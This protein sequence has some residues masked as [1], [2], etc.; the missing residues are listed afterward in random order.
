MNTGMT[1]MSDLVGA[2]KREA[3]V[4][5]AFSDAYPTVTDTEIRGALCDAFAAA[6]LDGF[7]G[8]LELDVDGQETTPD[9]S[10][11]GAALVVIYAGERLVRQQI[12]GLASQ[13]RYKAGPVE[14]ETSVAASVLAE[15]L[16]Q[17]RL[18]RAELLANA[19]R[20][21]GTSTF[22]LEG[23][24]SRGSAHNLYGGFFAYELALPKWDVF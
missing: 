16:K 15:D 7:F 22:V 3:A 13:A 10:V 5:G 4:P 14:M 1:A 18:R 9:L 19:Q 2:Y 11:A 20:N 12:R 23:Y 21:R 24:V 8:S 6:Q 17:L